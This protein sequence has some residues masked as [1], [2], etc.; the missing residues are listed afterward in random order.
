MWYEY[1]D[2]S[3]E[4]FKRYK[5]FWIYSCTI[6]GFRD[7]YTVD[8]TYY[9]KKDEND[10]CYRTYCNCFAPTF[11]TIE[12]ARKYVIARLETLDCMY[13]TPICERYNGNNKTYPV[14]EFYKLY[15][16]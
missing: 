5:V 4:E 6:D 8:E 9:M 3:D 7:S 11:I 1:V 10:E 2:Y 14:D 12:K 13:S 15:K 16:K